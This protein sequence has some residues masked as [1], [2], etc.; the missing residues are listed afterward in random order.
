MCAF[1]AKRDLSG[2][3]ELTL[4]IPSQLP[5]VWSSSFSVLSSICIPFLYIRLETSFPTSRRK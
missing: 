2:Y 4:P 3:L 5:H 1:W